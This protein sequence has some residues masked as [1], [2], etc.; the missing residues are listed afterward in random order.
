VLRAPDGAAKAQREEIF[1][2]GLRMPFGIAFWPPGPTLQYVY[3]ADTDS[4]VRF[5]YRNG[6]LIA[7]GSPQTIVI[8]VPAG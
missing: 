7:R 1:A 3:V 2:S 6:D 5:S 8:S 4:V